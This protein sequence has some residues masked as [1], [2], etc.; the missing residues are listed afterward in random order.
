MLQYILNSDFDIKT[1]KKHFIDYLEV[2]ILET[3][4][5]EYAIPSHQEKLIQMA[6]VK[7]KL[8]RQ[9]LICS[10]PADKYFDYMSWLCEMAGCIAVWNDRI[11][12]GSNVTIEQVNALL[13]LHDE[14]L[15]YGDFVK[16]NKCKLTKSYS[17]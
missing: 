5:V 3:G 15:Y 17:K 2:V 1:H 10:C 4:K 11:E 6:C 7:H 8:S 14:K 9:E 16:I 13:K 12:V